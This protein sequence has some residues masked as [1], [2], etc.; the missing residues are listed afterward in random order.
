M[1]C[2]KLSRVVIRC[3][4]IKSA[5]DPDLLDN[6]PLSLSFKI[7]HIFSH[8]LRFLNRVICLISGATKEHYPALFLLDASPQAFFTESNALERYDNAIQPVAD[9][10]VQGYKL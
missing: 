4:L 8:G 7:N 6:L 2:M 5:Y 9:F 1:V 3:R 10:C